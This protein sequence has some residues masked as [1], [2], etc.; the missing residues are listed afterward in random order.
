MKS[1]VSVT[2]KE[3]QTKQ[4]FLFQNCAMSTKKNIHKFKKR[5]QKTQA[6]AGKEQ[7][8]VTGR[9]QLQK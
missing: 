9:K 3:Q 5:K 6:A 8:G 4:T 2:T 1:H 7:Q